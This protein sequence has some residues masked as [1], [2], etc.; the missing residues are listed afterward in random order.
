MVPKAHIPANTKKYRQWLT[1]NWQ[2]VTAL[3]DT[4]ASIT[5]VRC[6]LVSSEQV[7]P[8]VVQQV[9]TADN[10]VSHYLW[11]WFPWIDLVH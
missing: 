6:H 4:G 8:D 3:S 2:G 5:T 7:I 1:I 9:V 11:L 10:L